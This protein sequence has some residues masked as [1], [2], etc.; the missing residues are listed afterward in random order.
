MA[1]DVEIQL[2]L[3][4]AEIFRRVQGAT[5][6]GLEEALLL[7][8]LPEAVKLSPVKTGTNRRSIDVETGI[9][10]KGEAEG[11]IF[12]QSGYGGYIEV[13][14]SRMPARPYLFPAVERN[15]EAILKAIKR[16]IP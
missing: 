10:S 11:M 15:S 4:L 16:R 2:R 7:D 9:N 5:E 1:F 8:V 6:D 3:Q 14:T 12:T 13:G